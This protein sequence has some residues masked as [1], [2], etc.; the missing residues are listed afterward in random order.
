MRHLVHFSLKY[1]CTPA[2]LSELSACRTSLRLLDIEQSVLVTD[3]CIA[4]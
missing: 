3:S 1:N 2:L 4:R